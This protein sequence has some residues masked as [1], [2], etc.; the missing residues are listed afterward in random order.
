MHYHPGSRGC[1]PLAAK[2]CYIPLTIIYMW[3]FYVFFPL[4]DPR[5]M[6]FTFWLLC[7]YFYCL[8]PGT[9][10]SVDNWIFKV[11]AC[12]KNFFTDFFASVLPF[13]IPLIMFCCALICGIFIILKELVKPSKTN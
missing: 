2:L 11:H 5:N 10:E 6:S 13:W 1:M 9:K 8:R 3:F 7:S 12:M 4:F